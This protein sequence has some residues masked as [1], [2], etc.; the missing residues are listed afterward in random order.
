M[1]ESFWFWKQWKVPARRA[2]YIISAFVGASVFLLA[3]TILTNDSGI[4][5]YRFDPQ[6]RSVNLPTDT[7]STAVGDFTL[8]D[9]FELV[10]QKAVG[11][12]RPVSPWVHHSAYVAFMLFLCYALAIASRLER[13]YYYVAMAALLFFLAML[14]LDLLKF[15]GYNGPWLFLLSAIFFVLPGYYFFA[16]RPKIPVVYRFLTYSLVALVYSGLIWWL[17]PLG[18]PWF[19]LVSYG[20]IWMVIGVILLSFIVGFDIVHM[21][22]VVLT[23]SPTKGSRYRDWQFIG[24]SSLYLINVLLLYLKVSSIYTLDI[25]YLNAFLLLAISA[26][27]GIWG[28]WHRRGLNMG[29]LRYSSLHVQWYLAWAAF[30]M[31]LLVYLHYA[32]HDALLE[33]VEDLIAYTH[34]GLGILYLLYVLRN[35]GGLIKENRPAWRVAYEPRRWPFIMVRAAGLVIV[36]AMFFRSNY[37][38]YFQTMSGYYNA[39]GDYHL[40]IEEPEIAKSF[41]QSGALFDKRNHKSNFSLAYMASAENDLEQTKKYL[42]RAVIKAGTPYA[43][44]N[45]ASLHASEDNTFQ[46]HFTLKAGLQQYPDHP[47][48]LLNYGLSYLSLG[49][50]DSALYHLDKAA[51]SKITK[52]YAHNNLLA[53]ALEKG[54]ANEA[55][56]LALETN[57]DNEAVAANHAALLSHAQIQTIKVNQKNPRITAAFLLNTAHRATF[58][59]DTLALFSWKN[60]KEQDTLNQLKDILAEISVPLMIK[61]GEPLQAL[62]ALGAEENFGSGEVRPMLA[63]MGRYYF[64]SNAF[65]RAIDFLGDSRLQ[66]HPTSRALLFLAQLQT[67]GVTDTSLLEVAAYMEGSQ[68]QENIKILSKRA[69]SINDT[70]FGGFQSPI[71][72]GYS[73]FAARGPVGTYPFL[74]SK[75]ITKEQQKKLSNTLLEVAM[76][77]GAYTWAEQLAEWQAMQINITN[78]RIKAEQAF[79]DGNKFE[80]QSEFRERAFFQMMQE[81]NGDSLLLKFRFLQKRNPTYLFAYAIVARKLAEIGRTDLGYE[82]LV[83]GLRIDP[84]HVALHQETALQSIELGL[85]SYADYSLEVL[86]RIMPAT[87]YSV[88]YQSFEQKKQLMEKTRENW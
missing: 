63:F 59:T 22:F 87:D 3:G 49:I 40:S 44:L 38:S 7:L 61:S 1:Q 32:G 79:I 62:E 68:N 51:Q 8:Y 15:A 78:P 45:L 56:V 47:V 80:I 2:F 4:F 21:F 66:Y 81:S 18:D 55:E 39:L 31:L 77:Q 72:Q 20:L 27:V 25:L 82:L 64:K 24:I 37:Y 10:Y 52:A 69:T 74:E 28:V 30:S 17:C 88:F 29:K 65:A 35:F 23:Y 83:E 76:A 33:V 50:T 42:E 85:Y 58:I 84:A 5:H 86:K 71:L 73:A 34:L 53:M 14:K 70:A 26:V 54:F 9:R 41:Y 75:D 46:E 19:H 67:L 43:F 12:L 48:L 13:I 6:I 60:L 16:F 57:P 36:A 11:E